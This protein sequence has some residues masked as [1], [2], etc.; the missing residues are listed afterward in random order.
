MSETIT[1]LKKQ[2]KENIQTYAILLAMGVIWILFSFLTEGRY[3][4]PQNISNLFRQ[5]VITSFLA[6]GMVLVIVTGNID[7]SVGKLAGF[8]SVIVARFQADIWFDYLPDM[9]ILTTIFSILI[10]IAVGTI[11]EVIQGYLVSYMHIPSFI[12]T[13]GGSWVLNGGILV[14][15][16]G[17]TIPAN[18][19]A[20]S[21][22]A[23]G[24]LPANVG[25]VV[26]GVVI[27][28]TIMTMLQGRRNK[29]KY[30]FKPLPL[31]IEAIR[32]A[33]LSLLIL[34]YVYIV[35]KYNG[36]QIPVMVLAVTAVIMS[37]VT[38]NT[39]VGR[40]AYA[41]GGNRDAARLSGVNIN[42]NI[43]MVFVLMGLMSGISG[44][45]LASYVGYG[46]IAAGQGY[47]L[48]AIAS[49]ILGGTSTL[50]GVGTIFGALIGSL[51]MA[52]LTSG[53]QMMNVPASWQYIL[54]GIVLVVAVYADVYL[55][56]NR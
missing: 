37:Y 18:Q 31:V 29:I 48:D 47:E 36:V 43:F 3:I 42:K 13:L 54:K 16:Q 6:V 1:Y 35:N 53:L 8:V 15:T 10:G 45:V 28:F 33:A 5:M 51:I 22:I 23:Q 41:I 30:G 55:K 40:Y 4:S 12:V 19:P 52:S 7:L 24:Y 38:T 27:L 21:Y 9:P 32:L 17:K 25:W 20:F 49:T 39:P 56:K 46:T 11:F 14:I 44:V 2:I 34:V 26:A 50:G